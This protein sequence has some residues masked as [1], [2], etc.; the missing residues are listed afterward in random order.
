MKKLAML[1][2]A[3]N[4][5]AGDAVNG[6]AMYNSLSCSGCHGVSGV[7]VGKIRLL[8]LNS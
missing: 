7:W 6:E 2:L 1:F 5:N 3:L 4:V 8:V